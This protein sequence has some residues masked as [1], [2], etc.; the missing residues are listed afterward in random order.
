MY[1]INAFQEGL[2]KRNMIN[3]DWLVTMINPCD[4]I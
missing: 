3:F 4:D 2:N 1:M